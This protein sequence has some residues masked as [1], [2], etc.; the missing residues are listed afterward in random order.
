MSSLTLRGHCN[1]GPRSRGNK[2][3]ILGECLLISS[4][5]SKAL[6]TLV[7]LRGLSSDSTCLLEAEPGK[8]DAVSKDANLVF[9]LSVY[10]LLA[11]V[12]VIID[13][14]VDSASLATSI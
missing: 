3:R 5:P 13:L 4:L 7:E 9:Y 10:K 6:R 8:H 11:I 2:Q 1:S 12:D 14:C